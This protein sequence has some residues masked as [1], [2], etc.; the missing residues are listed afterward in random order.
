[1]VLVENVLTLNSLNEGIKCPFF[2]NFLF[3]IYKV[4]SWLVEVA[5]SLYNSE[6]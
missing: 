1:M 2:F 5:T 6:L 4:K 3:E